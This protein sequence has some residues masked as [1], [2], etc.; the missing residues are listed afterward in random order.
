MLVTSVTKAET[1]VL[2][3]VHN[4]AWRAAYVYSQFS[5]DAA[6]GFSRMLRSALRYARPPVLL[7]FAEDRAPTLRR[8]VFRE[9]KANRAKVTARAVADPIPDVYRFLREVPSLIVHAEGYEADD[10]IG[11]FYYQRVKPHR[12]QTLVVSNDRDLYQLL[13][14][15]RLLIVGRDGLIDREKALVEELGGLDSAALV[16]C[17]KAILGDPS[18][19]VPPIRP[20]M[21]RSAVVEFLNRHRTNDRIIRALREEWRFSAWEIREY[22]VRY[23]LLFK[24]RVTAPLQVEKVK[25]FGNDR[26]DFKEGLADA[27][28]TKAE[29]LEKA[30]LRNVSVW[31]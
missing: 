11:A 30:R 20:R 24:L 16:P 1:V 5:D 14:E 2:V 19:N 10:V 6:Y 3:D 9:Y 18:D 31:A 21:R 12:K 29:R 22:V 27:V 7:V 15:K 25:L 8:R 28:G 13:D 4:I 26:F 23:R 17:Y